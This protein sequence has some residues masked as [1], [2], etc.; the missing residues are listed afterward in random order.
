MLLIM[1]PCARLPIG[2]N[3]HKLAPRRDARMRKVDRRDTYDLWRRYPPSPNPIS[4]L[5]LASRHATFSRRQAVPGESMRRANE[6][7]FGATAVPPT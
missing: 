2:G 3:R 1:D 4:K 5:A 7:H 6:P